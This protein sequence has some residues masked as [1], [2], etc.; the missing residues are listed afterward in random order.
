MSV[1]PIAKGLEGH[2]KKHQEF[3]QE[4]DESTNL[5]N[6]DWTEEEFQ[7]ASPHSYNDEKESCDV[8]GNL[9]AYI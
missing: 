5:N 2:L 3:K 7:T 8:I 9:N 6:N 4:E 1:F